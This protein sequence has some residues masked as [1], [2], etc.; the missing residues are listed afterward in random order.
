MLFVFDSYEFGC[1]K[2][3]KVRKQKKKKRLI[4]L[5]I[6]QNSTFVI[7]PETLASKKS[8]EIMYY[9]PL[10]LWKV[11]MQKEKEKSKRVLIKKKKRSLKRLVIIG[12]EPSET[13]NNFSSS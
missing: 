5:Q 13:L 12:T 10:N 8:Y 9:T 3:Y 2:K 7:K 1:W 4:L 11:Y 6:H